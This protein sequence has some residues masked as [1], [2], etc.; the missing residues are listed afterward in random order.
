LLTRK[1]RRLAEGRVFR[2]GDAAGYV[3]PFT[4]EGMAWALAGGSRL[5]AILA[6]A[7]V[8][9]GD[10]EQAGRDWSEAYRREV[11]RRQLVCRS[12]RLVL[13]TPWL[14][15]SLVRVLSF[16]PDLARPLIR[17]IHHAL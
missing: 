12:A 2:V 10:G 7:I 15:R 14:T 6:G 13:R 16:S 17:T 4:G 3:E 11:S 9:G 5:A 8:G 1:A